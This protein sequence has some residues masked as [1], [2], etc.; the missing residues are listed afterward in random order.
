MAT[1]KSA[2]IQAE[3]ER[4]GQ[5]SEARQAERVGK[6]T[7]AENEEIVDIVRGMSVPWTVPSSQAPGRFWPGC[8]VRPAGEGGE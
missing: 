1:S 6:S 5:I 2:K 8:E 3:M 7:G 4:S